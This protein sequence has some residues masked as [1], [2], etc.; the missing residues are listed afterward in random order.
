[1]GFA[2]RLWT[3]AITDRLHDI[4]VRLVADEGH[5]DRLAR[6]LLDGSFFESPVTT[7]VYPLFLAACYLV[8]DRSYPSVLMCITRTKPSLRDGDDFKNAVSEVVIMIFCV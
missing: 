3:A 4:P 6:A 5:Y 7:P 8:F 1:M 2:F